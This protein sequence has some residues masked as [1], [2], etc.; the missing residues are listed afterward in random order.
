MGEGTEGA[1]RVGNMTLSFRHKGP[2]ERRNCRGTHTH[3]RSHTV[4][5]RHCVLTHTLKQPHPQADTHTHSGAPSVTHP[6]THSTPSHVL[7][8]TSSHSHA[9]RASLVP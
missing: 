1:G 4:V 6:H 9:L 8:H 3:A 5:H 7:A 2:G